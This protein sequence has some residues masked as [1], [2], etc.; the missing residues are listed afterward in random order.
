L[1]NNKRIVSIVDDEIYIT[2]LFHEA[3]RENI[4]GISVFSF[5]D[6]VIGFEH[7][8]ENNAN[9][10][11]VISDLRMPGLNGLELLKKVKT[12]NP[13]VR[14]ILMSAYNFEEDEMYQQYMKEAV[15]N[16]SIEKPVTMNY[17][18]SNLF[19]IPLGPIYE[20]IRKPKNNKWIRQSGSRR[21]R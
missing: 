2:K 4:D 9:Y 8:T 13:K 7:F 16:S 17:F 1:F 14:T 5:I 6:P 18:R 21:A 11:L 15:I 3:L 12:S 10:A 19:S 20:N